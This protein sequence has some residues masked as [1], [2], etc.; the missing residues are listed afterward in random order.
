MVRVI[1][2]VESRHCL[3]LRSVLVVGCVCVVVCGIVVWVGVWLLLLRF[4]LLVTEWVNGG[5][6]EGLMG[7]QRHASK[8]REVAIFV[9]INVPPVSC[10]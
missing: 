4:C 8:K 1:I 3:P 10:V 7:S 2:D 6:G 5:G 9:W